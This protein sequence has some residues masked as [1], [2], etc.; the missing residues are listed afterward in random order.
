MASTG[1]L[2]IKD[3][4]G[5]KSV[6]NSERLFVK[7]CTSLRSDGRHTGEV[8]PIQLTFGRSRDATECTVQWG[9]TRVSCSIVAEL[10]PPENR[11][12]SGKL[13]FVVENVLLERTLSK[14]VNSAMDVESLCVVSGE[15]VWNLII[16]I[17]TLDNAGN[18]ID[19]T[20]LACLAALNHFRKP[21]VEVVDA[22]HPRIL[23]SDEREPTPLALHH[24][25]LCITF[26][27]ILDNGVATMLLDPSEREELIM[28]GS[29][30]FAFN[31]HSELCL[32]EFPGGCELSTSQLLQCSQL[33]QQKCVELCGMLEEAL[34]AADLKASKERLNRLAAASSTVVV[35]EKEYSTSEETQ[36][37]QQQQGQFQEEEEQYKQQALDYAIGHVAAKVKEKAEKVESKKSASVLIKSMIQSASL[38]HQDEKKKASPNKRAKKDMKDT[39]DNDEEEEEDVMMLQSEF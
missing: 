38:K 24:V 34:E 13:E 15:W 6:S 32:L 25:P 21:V 11:P 30:T 4:S 33:A 1:A 17:T 14:L 28:N 9:M 37:H 31:K 10:Q 20:V 2:A 7:Q 19:A 39:K 26:G 12:N 3:D 5:I 18:L 23:S 35:E 27:L 22:S 8:R 29:L 36:K 16:S